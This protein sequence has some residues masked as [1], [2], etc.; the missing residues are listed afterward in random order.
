LTFAWVTFFRGDEDLAFS[1]GVGG[2][3]NMPGTI[4][5]AIDNLLLDLFWVR[6]LSL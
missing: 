3:T 4:E 5:G 6:I 1:S 2:S